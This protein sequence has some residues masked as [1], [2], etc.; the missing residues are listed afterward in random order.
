M[1]SCGTYKIKSNQRPVLLL[2]LPEVVK[3]YNKGFHRVRIELPL[4]VA[5]AFAF[6]IGVFFRMSFVATPLPPYLYLFLHAC[7]ACRLHRPASFSPFPA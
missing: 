1:G 2:L 4:A 7:T 5:D 3:K 6:K